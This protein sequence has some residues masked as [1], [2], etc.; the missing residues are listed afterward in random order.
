[1]DERGRVFICD[2]E[3][4]RIQLFDDSGNFIEEWTDMESPGDLWIRDN[5]VYVV[6]QGP[7][8]GVSVWTLDGDLITRW[9]GRDDAG[10]PGV[11]GGHGICVDSQGSVYVTEIG[12]GNR[13]SKYARV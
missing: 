5:I 12:Q 2:R 4:H 6:E 7:G 8:T 10:A 13:V 1:M 9:R 3:N 11:I